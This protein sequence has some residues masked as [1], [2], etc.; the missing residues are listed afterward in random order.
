MY[1]LNIFLVLFVSR[2][3][4]VEELCHPS[5]CGQNTKCEVINTTPTCS[6][7]SGYVGNPLSGCRHECESDGEC[8]SQEMCKDFKCQSSCSQCG[9]GA[10]CVR[11]SNHRAV[12]E[13]PKVSVS[14]IFSS[15]SL[16]IQ[17]EFGRIIWEARTP[18]AVPNVTATAIVRPDVQPAIM[19]SARIHVMELVVLAPIAISVD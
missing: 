2:E 9:T 18:N 5:P 1:E 11:V 12:C 14:A 7:L 6:C 8:G 13:C 15:S 19:A 10:Q 17:F 4:R 16:Q 3:C